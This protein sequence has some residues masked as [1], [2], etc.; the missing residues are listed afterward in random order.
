M[1]RLEAVWMA[2]MTLMKGARWEW[3]VGAAARFEVVV[4]HV[5]HDLSEE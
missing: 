2:K 3:V 5:V 1:Y 4:R